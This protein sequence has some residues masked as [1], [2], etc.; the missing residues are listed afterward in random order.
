[1]TL[2]KPTARRGSPQ[3]PRFSMKRT[4]TAMVVLWFVS[5]VF[6]ALP[7]KVICPL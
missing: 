7:E 4:Q 6:L 3:G 2:T 1:M 5:S